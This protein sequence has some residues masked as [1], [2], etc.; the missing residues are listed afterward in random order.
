M[1]NGLVGRPRAGKSYEAVMF[2][3]LPAAKEGRLVVTNIPVKLDAVQ[4]YYGDDVANSII[5]VEAN[6]NE[7][8]MIRPFSVPEDFTKHDWKN[9]KGQGPL[10]VVDEAHLSLGLDAKKPVLEYL[11][12]HGHYG[13]DILVLTQSPRKL[14]RDLKDMIEVCW[15]CV[16]K[17]VFGDD[18]HYIKKTYH[19][20]PTRNEG[21]VHEEEREYQQQFFQFYQSHTQSSTSVDEA[22]PSDIKAKLNPY[23]GISIAMIVV[24]AVFSVM[25]LKSVIAPSKADEKTQ[26][27][28]QNQDTQAVIQKPVASRPSPSSPV[29]AGQP[30]KAPKTTAFHPFYKVDLHVESTAEYTMGHRL[31]KEVYFMASQN[32]Q[33]IFQIKTADLRLAGYDVQV[34]GDCAVLVTYGDYQDWITCDTPRMTLSGNSSMPEPPVADAG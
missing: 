9:D 11:S 22:K 25:T 19:G 20:V 1:I 6:Y 21:Y 14:H 17:S 31:V 10:F 26:H 18:T 3:I 2:H 24:G 8:G 23:K 30:A 29:P 15:R 27:Q 32:G 28:Q 12:L 5:V 34:Y 4:R 33:G 7:Y 13:H 16:K